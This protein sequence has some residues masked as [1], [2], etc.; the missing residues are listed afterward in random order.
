VAF[1]A[2]R[3]PDS[4]GHRCTCGVVSK[5][6]AAARRSRLLLPLQ[7]Q[8]RNGVGREQLVADRHAPSNPVRVA[9]LVPASSTFVSR[10]SVCL[11]PS[12][13]MTSKSYE[14]CF[15]SSEAT[16][17]IEAILPRSNFTVFLNIRVGVR[18]TNSRLLA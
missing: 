11:V 17:R 16:C 2:W 13:S 1:A 3:R 15:L 8:F 7:P 9:I 6:P 12:C 14:V 18:F 5:S 4:V 10:V